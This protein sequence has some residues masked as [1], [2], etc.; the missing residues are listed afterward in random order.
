MSVWELLYS[1]L[2]F[3][4]A[5]VAV[6]VPGWNAL[7]CSVV[8]AHAVLCDTGLVVLL[9][10]GSAYAL[11][12]NEQDTLTCCVLLLLQNVGVIQ[13]ENLFCVARLVSFTLAF[14]SGRKVPLVYLFMSGLLPGGSGERHIVALGLA[15]ALLAESAESVSVA[16]PIAVLLLLAAIWKRTNDPNQRSAT[17]LVASLVIAV[18]LT[19]MLCGGPLEMM[20]WALAKAVKLRREALLLGA[21]GGA[22][23]A[24]AALVLAARES[25]KSSDRK[26]FHV[27]MTVLVVAV[28][29][30]FGDVPQSTESISL[31]AALAVC[32][33]IVVETFRVF[34]GSNGVADLLNAW[35][36]SWLD[37]KEQ[38][39]NVAMSHIY[40]VVGCALPF[41]MLH[42]TQTTESFLGARL[43]GVISV[44]VGN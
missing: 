8:M 22:S 9:S 1:K 19:V 17:R 23:V 30:V 28:L 26:W 27:F 18:M 36:E 12:C 29:V 43:A 35:F 33:L 38:K 40:L 2:D 31:G 4:A 15:T 42:L 44:G 32:I 7:T 3:L 5:L 10:L 41:A 20:D 6:S 13:R 24:F 25:S 37:E 14:L 11:R 16:T 21:I 39:N 34:S